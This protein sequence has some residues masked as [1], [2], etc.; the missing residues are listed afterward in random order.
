MWGFTGSPRARIHSSVPWCVGAGDAAS[1]R[2]SWYA[3]KSSARLAVMR[4]SFWRRLPA[5]ALR[6]FAKRRSP[7][8]PCR[9]FSASNAV[10]GMNTSPRASKRAGM[11]LPWSRR[12][13]VA[14]VPTFAVTSSP[15]TPSP[16]V[17]ARTSR[18]ST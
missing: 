15:V 11:P 6:G 18:P 4:G 5:A 1:G 13:I 10:R 17:A 16:R 8:S 14:I 9:S 2:A 3:K 7:A 12:G